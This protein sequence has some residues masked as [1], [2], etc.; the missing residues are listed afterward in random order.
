MNFLNIP[1]DVLKIIKYNY[2]LINHKKKFQKTL[3]II[4]NKNHELLDLIYSNYCEYC[5]EYDDHVHG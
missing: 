5:G 1:I 3:V 4:K 2:N